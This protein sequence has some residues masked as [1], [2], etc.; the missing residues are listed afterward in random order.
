[1]IGFRGAARFALFAAPVVSAFGCHRAPTYYEDVRPLFA[2]H[3]VRCHTERGVAPVPVL[4]SFEAVKAAADR[5]RFSLQMRDMPPWGA[6]NTGLCGKW[7]GASWLE[8]EQLRLLEKWTEQPLKGDPSRARPATPP[9]E[10]PFR[11][12]GVTLDTGGDFSPGL[13]PAAYHCFVTAPADARDRTATAFRFTS[14]EPRSVEQ[15]TLYALDTAAAEEA[16]TGMDERDPGLGFTCYGTPRFDGARLLTSW[17]WDSPVSRMPAGFGVRVPGG[18]KLLVQIHYNPI[19]TGLD[20]PTHTKIELEL[21]DGAKV[22]SFRE[23]SPD[24]LNLPARST[25]VEATTEH[26][27]ERPL[28]LLGVVPRMHTL[29]RTMQLDRTSA[30]AWQCTGSFDHFNFYRQRLFVLERP[31]DLSRGTRLR[32]SCIYDTQSRAEVT[33]RGETISDEEC[34]AA[35]LVY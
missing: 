23:L 11:A 2:A 7:Q 33:H 24:Q 34:L 20:A 26:V 18:R 12:S 1:M 19:A 14:T 25:H 28:Q 4:D 27:V 5:I 31:L 30:G 13:G 29:G 15:V 3:C 10:P 8:D 6:E 17:T 16:A 21:T 9:A 32:V 35:L 22:A